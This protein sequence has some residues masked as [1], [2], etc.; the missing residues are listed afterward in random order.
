MIKQCE[1][2]FA[3]A[4]NENSVIEEHLTRV[5]NDKNECNNDLYQMK[6]FERKKNYP[7]QIEANR[8]KVLDLQ[9]QVRVLAHLSGT[10]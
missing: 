9:L 5:Q 3:V 6:I 10:G 7:V 8:K 4:E 1:R 2:E